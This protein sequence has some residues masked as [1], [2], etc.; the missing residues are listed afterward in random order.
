[1]PGASP[2][3]DLGQPPS[4]GAP[5]TGVGTAGAQ[6]P[7]PGVSG[8]SAP[9][10]YS[11]A[12]TGGNESGAMQ[13]PPIPI[14]MREQPP[15]PVGPLPL[16]AMVPL[17]SVTLDHHGDGSGTVGAGLIW[18]GQL[19]DQYGITRYEDGDGKVG[20]PILNWANIT[21]HSSAVTTNAELGYGPP[22]AHPGFLGFGLS[23]HPGYGY[24]GNAL[25]V[26][27]YGGYPCY[28]GPGY[29]LHYGYPK[30][31]YPYYEGIG[32]LYYD[33]PVVVTELD[34][35]SDFGPYTGASSY[36]FTHPSYAS[37]A[38]ATGSFVPGNVSLPDTNATN[39]YPEATI[40]PGE[41]VPGMPPGAMNRTPLQDRF[42]GMELEPT[43]VASGRKG[44]RIGSIIASSTAANAGLD[45]GDLIIS[46]NGQPTEQRQQLDRVVS[47]TAPDNILRMNVLKA[48]DASE[49]VI[50]IRMP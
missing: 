10:G 35:A 44:L 28:G 42:L 15:Q 19:P 30:F 37:E 33:P 21:P 14:P 27:A 18:M 12:L 11:G 1:M 40:T 20:G 31:A 32:Q 48:R 9:G 34:N 29:P 26:G 23:F 17:P 16:A 7:L 50:T 5:G 2:R 36:A 8:L 24:G 46:V 49:Q 41:S 4:G 38:A 13:A 47:S 39:P 22:G 45:V 25:G 43:T 3:A 6:P